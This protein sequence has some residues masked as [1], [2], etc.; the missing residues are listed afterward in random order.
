VLRHGFFSFGEN[1]LQATKNS[2][3]EKS[4]KERDKIRELKKIENP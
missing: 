4:F 2:Y 3:I 1:S